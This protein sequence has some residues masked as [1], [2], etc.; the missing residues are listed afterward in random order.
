MVRILNEEWR[1]TALGSIPAG[2]RIVVTDVEGARL[3]VEQLE[4]A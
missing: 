1:A 2:S 4:D 3:M